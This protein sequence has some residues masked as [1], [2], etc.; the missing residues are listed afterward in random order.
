MTSMMPDPIFRIQAYWDK[1]EDQDL[2]SRI[3]EIKQEQARLREL[4]DRAEATLLRRLE[5]RGAKELH[6]PE[7]D[8]KLDT[9]SP[10]YDYGKL[11][12]LGELVPPDVLLTGFTPEHQETQVVTVKEKWNAVK[13][14]TWTKYGKEIQ[15]VIDGARMESGPA[16]LKISA[17]K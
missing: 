7:L 11:R 13:F 12:K 4:G 10:S 1:L 16:R 2:A 15:E 14:K 5:G 9:P 6:H 3:W 8:I 17:K